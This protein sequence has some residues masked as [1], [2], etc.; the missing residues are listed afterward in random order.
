[1]TKNKSK[2]QWKQSSSTAKI[3]AHTASSPKISSHHSV[4]SMRRS[5]SLGL[6]PSSWNSWRDLG[7]EPYHRYSYEI[8][9]L[10]DILISQ[11]YTR[12]GNWWGKSDYR[13]TP[14]SEAFLTLKKWNQK[15]KI[16]WSQYLIKQMRDIEKHIDSNLPLSRAWYGVNILVPVFFIDM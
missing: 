13:K 14:R 8:L 10:V 15:L 16:I 4:P 9:V 3:I 12:K 11:H 7:C 2:K 1:M 5:I 6:P